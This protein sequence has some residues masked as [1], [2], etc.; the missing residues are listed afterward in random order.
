[1]KYLHSLGIYHLSINPWNILIESLG[2]V[3]VA[4]G[5]LKESELGYWD[6]PNEGA[7]NESEFSALPS[8]WRHSNHG[9]DYEYIGEITAFWSSES[10][11][12]NN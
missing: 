7:T 1:M 9:L 6:L 8:G 4:G 5:K 2:G 12:G 3:D 10:I 11:N